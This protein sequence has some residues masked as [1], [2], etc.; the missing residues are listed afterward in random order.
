MLTWRLKRRYS[1][2]KLRG[3]SRLVLPAGAII[4]ALSQIT[5]VVGRGFS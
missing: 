5:D 2:L 3:Y 4:M 1:G